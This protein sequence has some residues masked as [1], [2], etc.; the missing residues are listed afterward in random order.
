MELI[1]LMQSYKCSTLI[2]RQSEGVTSVTTSS[3]YQSSPQ[4]E[5]VISFLDRMLEA[6]G[7]YMPIIEDRQLPFFRKQDVLKIFVHEYERLYSGSI[8]IGNYF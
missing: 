4:R 1:A 2:Q 5:A 6:F 7:N 3:R 8:P